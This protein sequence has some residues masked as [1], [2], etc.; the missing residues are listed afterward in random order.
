MEHIITMLGSMVLSAV[1]IS[2]PI[3]CTLSFVYTWDI[4]LKLLLIA[5]TLLEY[6]ILTFVLYN[7]N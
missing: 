5:A 2:L 3:L 7:E 4:L 6:L 1:I